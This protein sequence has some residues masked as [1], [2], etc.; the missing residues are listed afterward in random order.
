MPLGWGSRSVRSWGPALPRNRISLGRGSEPA[1]PDSVRRIAPIC[2]K[3]NN[4][5]LFFFF[6][7]VV[8][9]FG[10]GEASFK[11]LIGLLKAPRFALLGTS[12]VFGCTERL[13]A[14]RTW[15]RWGEGGGCTS[16]SC[17]RGSSTKGR[18]FGGT[19]VTSC[20]TRTTVGCPL[21]PTPLLVGC[22][23]RWKRGSAGLLCVGAPR[24]VPRL[25]RSVLPKS[26]SASS[27]FQRQRVYSLRAWTL[28][29]KRT[30]TKKAAGFLHTL[31]SESIE[32]DKKSK[33]FFFLFFR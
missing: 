7:P 26:S 4:Y 30:R 28:Y 12:R 25:R 11:M 19:R 27:S 31:R 29:G 8:V 17:T 16:R 14:L 33:A 5:F 21:R 18:F 13:T 10:L 23:A 32:S 1:R 20:G 24:Y 15:A 9:F 22:S 6:S 2:Q 3:R